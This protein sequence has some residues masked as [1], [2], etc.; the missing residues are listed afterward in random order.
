MRILCF[1]ENNGFVFR[2]QN[3]A[4]TKLK[5]GNEKKRICRVIVVFFMSK[6][7]AG[8]EALRDDKSAQPQLRETF[9]PCENQ[10][11]KPGTFGITGDPGKP[12]KPNKFYPLTPYNA[13]SHGTPFT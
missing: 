2:P 8:L 11:M 1:S 3:N 5:R 12:Q 10:F 9:F 6:Q 7:N 4:F 13:S